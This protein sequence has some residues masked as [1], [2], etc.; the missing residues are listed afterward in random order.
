MSYDEQVTP[1][2]DPPVVEPPPTTAQLS[3]IL[4]HSAPPRAGF[5]APLKPVTGDNS[6]VSGPIVDADVSAPE[7][8]PDPDVPDAPPEPDVPDAPPEP[9]VPDAPPEP[10][11]PDAPPEPDVPDAPPQ[12]VAP[13]P[14]IV[15]D[16]IPQPIVPASPSTPDPDVPP[17]MPAPG[18]QLAED[19]MVERGCGMCGGTVRVLAGSER[20]ELGHRLEAAHVARKRRWWSRRSA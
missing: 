3:G 16:L 9:D 13:D 19:G 20:C 11:V 7:G 18:P 5:V 10:D 12:P 1:D 14:P 6:G 4:A 17:E 15:P 8:G 2:S